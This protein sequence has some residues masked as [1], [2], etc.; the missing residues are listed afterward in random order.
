PYASVITGASSGNGVQLTSNVMPGSGTVS[1]YQW[2]LN[3]SAL[4][5]ETYSDLVAVSDGNYQIEVVNSNGCSIRSAAVAVTMP[6]AAVCQLTVPNSVSTSDISASTAVLNWQQ[7]PF[8]DSL[9]FRI[10]LEGSNQ[11]IYVSLPYLGQTSYVL[12]GLQPNKKYSWRMRTKCGNSVSN[13]SSRI[14]FNTL[15]SGTG[16]VGQ[17]VVQVKTLVEG[18][19]AYPNPADNHLRLNIVAEEIS[20]VVI[21]WTDVMGRVVSIELRDVIEGESTIDLSAS[22]IPNGLYVLSLIYPEETL[23]TM[24]SI[25]HN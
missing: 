21:Q 11:Y 19:M 24:V 18:M 22:S 16:R 9:L 10:R 20:Q 15:S 7:V 5:G 23:S 13:Y 14:I 1:G 12:T 3:N 6:T 17:P 2:Y 4:V 8:C 25:R